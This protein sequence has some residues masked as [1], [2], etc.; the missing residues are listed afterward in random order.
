MKSKIYDD[1]T[2][3]QVVKDFAI[4]FLEEP[5]DPVNELSILIID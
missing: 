1:Y 2:L 3:G 4:N 5:S